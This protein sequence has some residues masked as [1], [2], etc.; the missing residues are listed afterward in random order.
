MSFLGM[1]FVL[2]K[3]FRGSEATLMW[4]TNFQMG[5]CRVTFALSDSRT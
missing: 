4:R 1:G 2:R 3:E 5:N